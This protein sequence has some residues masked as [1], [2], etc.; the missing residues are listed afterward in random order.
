MAINHCDLVANDGLLSIVEFC[1]PTLGYLLHNRHPWLF[2]LG[3][4]SDVLGCF[5]GVY[6]RLYSSE[7]DKKGIRHYD[8]V[9]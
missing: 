4:G 1:A 6:L 7:K 3:C 5:D 8:A 2:V 9:K